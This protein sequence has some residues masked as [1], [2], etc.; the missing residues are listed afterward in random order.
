LFVSREKSRVSNLPSWWTWSSSTQLVDATRVS[1]SS[2]P[3]AATQLW[4][5]GHQKSGL[6]DVMALGRP[7]RS[8]VSG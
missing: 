5:C 3:V 7:V 8:M 2:M 6:R 1:Y 4:S